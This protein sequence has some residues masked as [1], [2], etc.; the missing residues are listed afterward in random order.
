MQVAMAVEGL[1]VL[2]R[3]YVAFT[4]QAT[5]AGRQWQAGH[6]CRQAVAGRPLMQ[7]GSGRQATDAG[8]Q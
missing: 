3:K 5:D 2:E 4:G 1:R 8:R 7:A 6:G